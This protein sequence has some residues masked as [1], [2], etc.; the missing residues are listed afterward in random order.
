MRLRKGLQRHFSQLHDTKATL[1]KGTQWQED[2]DNDFAWWQLMHGKAVEI[3]DQDSHSE[4]DTSAPEDI[5][6]YDGPERV[7]RIGQDFG[8][9]APGSCCN[10]RCHY[11]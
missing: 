10:D 11:R 9:N 1:T 5:R 2:G 4:R 8:D 7:L 6:Y 3:Y